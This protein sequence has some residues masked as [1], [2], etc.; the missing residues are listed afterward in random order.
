MTQE[1]FNTGAMVEVFLREDPTA[2][3]E[4]D[5]IVEG[6]VVGRDEIGLLL[7][8]GIDDFSRV[9]IPWANVSQVWASEPDEEEEESEIGGDSSEP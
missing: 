6:Q 2:E 7:D 8:T 9:F 3:E 1:F 4:D 5:L